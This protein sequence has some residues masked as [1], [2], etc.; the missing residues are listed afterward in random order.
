MTQALTTKRE[1]LLLATLALVQ[2]TVMVD[3]LIMAPLGPKLIAL[4]GISTQQFGLAVSAYVFTAGVC[5]FLGAFFIDRFDRKQ[6]LVVSY[7]GFTLGTFACGFAPSYELLVAARILTGVFGGIIGTMIFAIIADAIPLERRGRSF[8]I[9]MSAFSL[10]SIAGI[11]S[12]L[13]F[14]NVL[15]WHAPFLVLAGFSALV[16]IMIF[17][18]VPSMTAHLLAVSRSPVVILRAIAADP[19]QLRAILLVMCLAIGQFSILPFLTPFLVSNLGVT[20]MQLPLMYLIS[21]I[22]TVFV[23]PLLGVLSDKFSKVLIY[24]V[25]ATISLCSIVVLVNLKYGIALWAIFTVT[26]VFFACIG[27]RMIPAMTIVQGTVLPQER[28]SFTSISTAIQQVTSGLA[29]F[30]AG[31]IV[32]KGLDGTIQHYD[33]VGYVAVLF[34]IVSFFVIRSIR[35]VEMPQTAMQEAAGLTAAQSGAP[36]TVPVR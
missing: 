34:T 19:N 25:A 17:L 29:T 13:Y 18:F 7:I 16:Q 2:F 10:A 35:Q 22:V 9:V 26:T 1:T 28:G 8:A 4:W 20:E 27:G 23:G 5:G 21:G 14:A 24:S 11:P 36:A 33:W 15:G 3:F 32:K 6:V 12:G 31:F 30:G